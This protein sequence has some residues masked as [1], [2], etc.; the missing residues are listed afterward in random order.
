MGEI[1]M[2]KKILITLMVIMMFYGCA[3]QKKEEQNLNVET[4]SFNGLRMP[5]GG[6]SEIKLQETNDLS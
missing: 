2:F 6:L 1:A 5:S 3:S 4:L